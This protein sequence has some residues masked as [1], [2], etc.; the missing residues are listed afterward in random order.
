MSNVPEVNSVF[1]LIYIRS[2]WQKQSFV[3]LFHEILGNDEVKQKQAQ[4]SK[5]AW[6][7][8]EN[9]KY[10]KIQIQEMRINMLYLSLM[11]CI[12]GFH[13]HKNIPCSSRGI[14]RSYLS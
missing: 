10:E 9:K 13:E 7:D 1:S 5:D 4:S 11:M 12:E 14:A 2:L 3:F 6:L 8:T